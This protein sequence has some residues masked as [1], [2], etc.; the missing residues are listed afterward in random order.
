MMDVN[1]KTCWLACQ[2]VGRVMIAQRQ[3]RII[4]FFSNAGMHGVPGYPAYSPAKAGVIALTRGLAVEWGPH[5][6]CVNALSPG[7]AI[8]PLNQD[9]LA[10][11]ARRRADP[12]T[13]AARQAIAGR[14]VG[15]VDA[16]PR[17]QCRTVDQ[18]SYQ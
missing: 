8:N 12:Q 3:G 16:V 6:I 5:G 10:N 11:S 18:W 1:L 4:N 7:F 9:A 15:W 14:R 17:L 13:H 2:A